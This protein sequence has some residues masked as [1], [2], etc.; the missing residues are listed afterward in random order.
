VIG[1]VPP[2]P[3]GAGALATLPAPMVLTT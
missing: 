1:A 3:A 2:S